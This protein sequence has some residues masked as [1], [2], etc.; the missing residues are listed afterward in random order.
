M[1]QVAGADLDVPRL[2]VQAGCASRRCRPR[3]GDHRGER[4]VRGPAG[5]GSARSS[6]ARTSPDGAVLAHHPAEAGALE[7]G[8]HLRSNSRIGCAAPGARIGLP[9]VTM[10]S[11]RSGRAT[12]QAARDQAAEAV[13]DDRHLAPALGSRSPRCAARAAS[14]ASR[15]QPTLACIVRAVGPVAQATQVPGHRPRVPSP[16]MKPGTSTTGSSAVLGWRRRTA[17][18]SRGAAGRGRDAG[19]N[20]AAS[21]D[22]AALAGQ[23]ARRPVGPANPGGQQ[24]RPER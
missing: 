19:T 21:T 12:G 4:D 11:T 22:R 18:P 9:S 20:R 14:A 23:S 17:G 7:P 3:R 10:P 16:A 5:P 1:P 13:P 24:E 15:V 6:P 2:R 8:E